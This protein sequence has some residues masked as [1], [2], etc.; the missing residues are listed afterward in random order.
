[1]KPALLVPVVIA[2]AALAAPSGAQAADCS[3]AGIP[4]GATK[5]VEGPEAL[6]Y[7]TFDGEIATYF[8]CVK[9]TGEHVKFGAGS[10]DFHFD[11]FGVAGHFIGYKTVSIGRPGAY[12]LVD[13]GTGTTS[14]P[15][16]LDDPSIGT[17]GDL[18]G[19]PHYGTGLSYYAK[20]AENRQIIDLLPNATDVEVTPGHVTFSQGTGGFDIDTTQ[21]PLAHLEHEKQACKTLT[22]RQAKQAKGSGDGAAVLA[23][24]LYIDKFRSCS[25]RS[26]ELTYREPLSKSGRA[27]LVG[28]AVEGL[29]RVK[30]PKLPKTAAFVEKDDSGRMLSLIKGGVLIQLRS[31]ATK[32][33]STKALVAAMRHVVSSLT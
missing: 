20:D 25:W 27:A 7:N 28:S 14:P 29:T 18:A 9:P 10:A 32:P 6:A 19:Y 5:L 16:D 24:Q 31:S 3:V 11:R 4:A 22:K 21:P 2:T 17:D 1:M 8:A 30:S 15:R 13:A 12:Y 26:L 23:Q 33:A